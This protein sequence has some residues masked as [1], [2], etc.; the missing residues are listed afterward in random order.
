MSGFLQFSSCSYLTL[1]NS[2]GNQ[3]ERVSELSLY[4]KDGTLENLCGFQ[5]LHCLKVALWVLTSP[6]FQGSP[7]QLSKAPEREA[8]CSEMLAVHRSCIIAK[9][10]SGGKEDVVLATKNVC[11]SY[12]YWNFVF[13]NYEGFLFTWVMFIAS[14][15]S[16]LF[17]IWI[18]LY[19][20]SIQSVY[21]KYIFIL[22][23]TFNFVVPL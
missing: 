7:E 12:M 20:I 18:Y 23:F 5:F 17:L 13:Y 19:N 6:H 22:P 9:M 15:S 16:I 3:T 10:K 1:G 4:L 2:P 8:Q 11:Y 14:A 21:M